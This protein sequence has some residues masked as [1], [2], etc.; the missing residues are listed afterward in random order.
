M[1][2][3]EKQQLTADEKDVYLLNKVANKRDRQAME[4]FYRTYRG[5][6]G[7]FLFRLLHNNALVEE[8]YNDVMLIIWQK[9]SQ[10][11][12]NS[13]VSTWV[14]SIAYRHGFQQLRK[15]NKYLS[16]VRETDQLVATTATVDD[17]QQA[18]RKALFQLS[19]E[20]R[21]VI[22]LVYFMG[23]NYT[24][25]AEI[26]GSPENTVK[27]RMFYARRHLQKELAKIGITSVM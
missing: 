12:G 2:F 11:N 20:H 10:F 24:E 19:Y 13:K 5:R 17:Q 18:I 27:T 26:T 15:E 25:V 22:E 14:L 9:A 3:D 16:T 23:N 4:E 6:L 8:V 7:A 21:T 1:N